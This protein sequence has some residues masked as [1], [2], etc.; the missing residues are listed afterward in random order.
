MR[1]RLITIPISHYGERARWALDLAGVDY[2]EVHHL[3]MFSWVAAFRHGRGKTLPVLVTDGGVLTDSE[4]IVRWASERAAVPL[5]PEGPQGPEAAAERGR[6]EAL[7]QEFAGDYGIETRRAAYDWFF[8]S[9][10]RC[11]PYNAGHAPWWQVRTLGL[12]QR[13]ASALARRYLQVAPDALQRGR[14]LI[15]R[16]LDQVAR[17]LEDGRRYLCGERFSAADL[18][19]AAMSAPALRPDRYGVPLPSLEELPDDAARRIRALR[20]HPAGRFALRLYDE[21]RPTPAWLR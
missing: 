8:R 2:E 19:F 9:L 21:E 3:Q 13:P 12:L 5:Y 7:E 14:E 1:P 6:V 17:T 15:E 4:D 20:E 16:T 10:P 18:T 11:L